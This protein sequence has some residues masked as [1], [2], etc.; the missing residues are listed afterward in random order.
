MV[1]AN[2]MDANSGKLAFMQWRDEA[3]GSRV[4]RQS[5]ALVYEVVLSI[6]YANAEIVM[7]YE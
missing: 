7:L 5:E 2:Y 6:N 1:Q 4:G 3:L